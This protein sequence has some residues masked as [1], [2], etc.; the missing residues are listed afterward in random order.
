MKHYDFSTPELLAASKTWLPWIINPDDR[1][2]A[3]IAYRAHPRQDKGGKDKRRKAALMAIGYTDA[4]A[5]VI[6]P[7]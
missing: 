6:L 5:D 3:A 1:L 2:K 4:Q 7:K